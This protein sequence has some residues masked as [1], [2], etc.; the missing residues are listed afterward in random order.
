MVKKQLLAMKQLFATETMVRMVKED[1]GTPYKRSWSYGYSEEYQLY[2]RYLFFDAVVQDGILKVA[3]FTR[4]HIACGKIAPQF[5]IYISKSEGKWTTYA[6]GRWL[7]AK[8]DNLNYDLDVGWHHGNHPWQSERA[9]KVV[10]DYF[11]TDS[12]PIRVAVLD[13]QNDMRKEEVKKKARSITDRIDSIMENVPELPKDFDNWVV[14]SAFAPNKCLFY[15]YGTKEGYCTAC[16][17]EVNVGKLY[18][19]TLVKC[20]S[21]GKKVV[22]RAWKKQKSVRNRKWIGIIQPL[23]DKSGYVLR[24]FDCVIL[25]YQENE[26]R[27][28]PAGFSEEYRI[29]LN[30]EFERREWFQYGE[31]KSTGIRRWNRPQDISGYGGY[32]SSPYVDDDVV[33]YHRNIKRLRKG[34]FM[35]Y[36]PWEQLLK[37]QEGHFSHVT[38]ELYSMRKYPQVEYLIKAKLYNLAKEVLKS[39]SV[40]KGMDMSGRRLWEMLNIPKEQLKDCMGMNIKHRELL[41]LK[42]ANE[43]RVKITM[44][45]LREVA[46]YLDENLAKKLFKYG[47]WER[48]YRYIREELEGKARQVADYIDYLE[49][50]EFLRIPVTKAELFPKGF[51]TVHQ[52]VAMQR[53][54]K[55]DELK[56]KDI[57]KKNLEFQML[58]PEVREI[59]GMENETFAVVIPTCKEDFQV[60]GRNN[61]NCVGG[62]YFDKMLQ[63]KCVVFF[64]RKK[65]NIE[66]AFCT[67]EMKG[68]EIV[69]CRAVRNSTAP[70]E[71]MAFMDKL[72]KE[73]EQRIWKKAQAAV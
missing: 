49:D 10:N 38:R 20:P 45:Q 50:L 70:P 23:M 55:E 18:N 1:K 36:I 61:H 52:N 58:L 9:K 62:S 37:A 32:Y 68:S 64:L 53:Q 56:K 17:K 22:A 33:L 41:I 34:T 54:E 73:V 24:M 44:E 26:W 21:C 72:A 11:G 63:R 47:H 48:M 4:K 28:G 69:Q 2:D 59:Y 8:I 51:Q 25:R 43:Y 39:Y 12:L 35:E 13:W 57:S 42:K 66:E 6:D 46:V 40:P 5:E 14:R 60:E 71:A 27:M 65:E 19:D 15:K 30:T 31:F 67:V 29:I 3:A 16:E 7:S